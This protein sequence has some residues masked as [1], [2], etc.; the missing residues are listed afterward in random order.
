[1][2]NPITIPTTGTTPFKVMNSSNCVLTVPKGKRDAYIAAGWT[3]D[4]FKGGVVEAEDEDDTERYDVNRDGSI[5]IA[6]VTT[7]V[8]VI[9]GKPIQ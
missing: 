3:E 6:D 4:V 2:E 8:N 1:M 9:L 7:L 5:S